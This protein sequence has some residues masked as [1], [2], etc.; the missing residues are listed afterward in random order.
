M[1]KVITIRLKNGTEVEV[2]KS[3]LRDTYINAKDCSTEYN[4]KDVVKVK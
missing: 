1:N 2:Y 3:S 4:V